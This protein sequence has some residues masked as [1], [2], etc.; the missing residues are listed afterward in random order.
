MAQ[1]NGNGYI[2]NSAY[3]EDDKPML[4]MKKSIDSQGNTLTALINK[5][6]QGNLHFHILYLPALNS[7]SFKSLFYME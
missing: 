7:F 5:Q 2:T 4:L 1:S 3:D 6:L